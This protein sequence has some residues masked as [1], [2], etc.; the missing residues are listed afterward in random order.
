MIFILSS[1]FVN[2]SA[3]NVTPV[4]SM[5]G[6]CNNINYYSSI[7][8]LQC[9]Y[10]LQDNTYMHDA[11]LNEDFRVVIPDNDIFVASN[12]GV[13]SNI[14]FYDGNYQ[15]VS[16][17]SIIN[18]G[19]LLDNSTV[20]SN[21]SYFTI[22]LVF[23]G[24]P[25]SGSVINAFLDHFIVTDNLTYNTYISLFDQ[26]YEEGQIEGF[27]ITIDDLIGYTLKPFEIFNIELMYGITIGNI[28]FISIMLGLIG[29]LLSFR[30][31]K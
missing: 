18:G 23:P 30:K 6:T 24:D 11:V 8:G 12:G 13:Q 4:V 10:D 14:V 21:T 9:I 26:G 5:Q 16:L 20:V 1:Y 19:T 22:N 3:W 15:Y 25:P 17:S 27:E 29:M 31:G 28:A 7:W 2:L